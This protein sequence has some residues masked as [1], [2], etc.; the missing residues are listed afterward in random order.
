ME[1]YST[2]WFSLLIVLCLLATI[3]PR[4][5]VKAID[6]WEDNKSVSSAPTVQENLNA[7]IEQP[8]QLLEADSQLLRYVDELSFRKRNHVRRLVEEEDLS[9]YV[10]LNQDGSRTVYYMDEPVKYLDSDGIVK[11]KNLSLS[12]TVAG[13]ETVQNDVQLIFPDDPGI[14]IRLEYQ[15]N[16]IALTPQ[17]GSLTKAAVQMDNS[18]T[19]PDYFG[20]GVSLRYTPTLSGLK[21]DILLSEYTGIHSFTFLLNTGGLELYQSEDE[22]YLAESDT[23]T[24]R[25]E[26]GDI[27]VFDARGRF[28]LG[29]MAVDTLQ[30][31][32]QYRLTISVD[33]A[34]LL[35]ENTTYPV[36]I[37]PTLTVAY[38]TYGANAIEDVSIYSGCP[39]VNGDWVYLHCGYY[40]NTYKVARTLVRLPGLLGSSVYCFP[41]EFNI[42]KVEFH[43]RDASGTGGSVV[44][45]YS[46]A[47]DSSWVESNATWN[48][49]GAI[50]G[51]QYAAAC[52]QYETDTV[53]DITQLVKNWQSGVCSA[54]AGF[55]LRNSDESISDK[56]LYSAEYSTVSYRPYVVVTYEVVAVTPTIT[57]NHSSIDVDEGAGMSLT[58]TTNPAGQTVTWSSE[59]ETIATVHVSGVVFGQK[60]GV[61]RV[62]ATLPNG[63]SASCT[64]YVTIPDGV[65][66]VKNGTGFYLATYGSTAEN[67]TAHLLTKETSGVNRMRQL[68]RIVHL[69][70]NYYSIRPMHKLDMALHVSNNVVD[71]TTVGTGDSFAA[72]PF[73]NRWQIRYDAN[74]YSILYTGTEGRAM[75]THGTTS[76]GMG[77]MTAPYQDNSYF[78]WHFESVSGVFLYDSS[79]QTPYTSVPTKYL[80]RE[81]SHT[82]ERMQ[83]RVVVGG[84]YQNNQTVTW[85][86]SNTSSGMV[87]SSGTYIPYKRG[88]NTITASQI[89]NG[90]TYSAQYKIICR[91]V[92]Y[93]KNYY[94]ETFEG[95]SRLIGLIDGAVE[96]LNSAYNDYF[97][98]WFVMDGSPQK[99]SGSALSICPRQSTE[100]CNTSKCG[101]NCI[102][103]HKNLGRIAD[104]AYYD[105]FEPNHVTVLWSDSPQGVFC[106]LN[107][108]HTP[109]QALGVTMGVI[110]NDVICMRPVVQMLTITHY[111]THVDLDELNEAY[112]SAVLAHE[113]AH[114]LNLGEVYENEYG[115]YA[116]HAGQPGMQCVMELFNAETVV[117]FITEVNNGN[118][119]ALCGYCINK[120][121]QNIPSNAYES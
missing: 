117:P 52:P 66:Y 2:R 18:V 9:T 12:E 14:G 105:H 48:N 71:I 113:I 40:D 73:A 33:P 6:N 30:A 22:Y 72:V 83:L 104:E 74:G 43:I 46:N 44:P 42:T 78:K 10:F 92:I 32:Q 118:R 103:H 49:A 93:V 25:I 119:N 36:M 90:Q 91:E 110:E 38:N 75:R 94:D 47:G 56:A 41:S 11:E 59:S 121:L 5:S 26:M 70:N 69:S 76:P 45:L 115:D 109:T 8:T 17:G 79:N 84:A 77:V 24:Q 88:T 106:Y 7:E 39:N 35:D 34:F 29:T 101:S 64:V 63:A 89:I 3:F 100:G 54:N 95:N 50:L 1:K 13:F 20:N 112:V 4:I 87:A 27:V 108:R 19:Y 97:Q 57:L 68:W 107:G 98:L 82:L 86:A 61:T 15:G 55:I 111:D 116:N 28:S 53:Y 51:T 81:S 31:R 120:L 99:Y 67:T 62:T 21:E 60:A 96:F 85:S 16:S 23:G 58:A 37:D 65:Y 80:D 102:Q 114:T